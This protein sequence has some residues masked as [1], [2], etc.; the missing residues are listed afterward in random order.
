M[1]HKYTDARYDPCRICKHPRYAHGNTHCLSCLG[2]TDIANHEFSFNLSDIQ[3][4]GPAVPELPEAIGRIV[5][6]SC[7][8][9][10]EAVYVFPE[11]AT[12]FLV[13]VL[14]HMRISHNVD[15]SEMG[16]Q[17]H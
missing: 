11:E 17:Y 5:S 13:R 16:L 1:A 6:A 12:I 2:T 10:W 8:C 3:T 7:K 14:D 15:L 4:P 9:G